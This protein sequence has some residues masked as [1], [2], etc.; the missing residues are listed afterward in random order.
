V[1]FRVAYSYVTLNREN[2]RQSFFAVTTSYTD[3]NPNDRRIKRRRDEVY[4]RSST[5]F[6][7]NLADNTVKENGFRI[8]KGGF[9]IDH[10]LYFTTKD[11]LSLKI[12]QLVPE[13]GKINSATVPTIRVST[14][15]VTSPTIR[16]S[17][18]PPMFS[19]LYRRRQSDI[20]FY[21]DTLL[22]DQ[23]GNIDKIDQVMFSGLMGQN[24][25]G[26]MLPLEYEL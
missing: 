19:V 20:A 17:T 13:R 2:I 6:F 22:V 14:N 21:T 26:D 10:S 18:D 25:A 12:I 16:M 7:K 3:L 8:F 23:Y 4:D 9:P 5:F 24:R 11:T 1:D 15:P